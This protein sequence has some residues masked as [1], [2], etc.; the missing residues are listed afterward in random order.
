VD[1]AKFLE[2][3]GGMERR[4]TELMELYGNLDKVRREMPKENFIIDNLPTNIR[5]SLMSSAESLYFSADGVAKQ[6]NHHPDL[7]ASEHCRVVNKMKTCTDYDI[8]PSGNMKIVLV[9]EAGNPYF[10]ILKTAGS[11]SEVYL[12]SVYKTDWEY[13]K[14]WRKKHKSIA[15]RR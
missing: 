2:W 14:N 8:F 1:E 12:V 13:A 9:T 10:A 3:F 4:Y 7:T 6:V 5:E 11:R 15:E